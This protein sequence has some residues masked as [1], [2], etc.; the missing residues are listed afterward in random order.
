MGQ[1]LQ[2]INEAV[3]GASDALVTNTLNATP[4]GSADTSILR[5]N[6]DPGNTNAFTVATTA[7]DGT[8][9]LIQEPGIYHASLDL[10][11]DGAVLVAAGISFGAATAVAI[12]ADPVVNVANVIASAD[13]D[14][15]ANGDQPVHLSVVFQVTE[16]AAVL[17][18]AASTAAVTARVMFHA[19]NSAG[20]APGGI[21]AAGVQYRIEKLSQASL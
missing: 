15:N 1:Q 2:S 14:G 10:V 4:T 11:F 9:I 6:T 19:T 5:F 21:T 20:A 18:R 8:I 12:T 13:V 17:A 3:L 16:A 7:A